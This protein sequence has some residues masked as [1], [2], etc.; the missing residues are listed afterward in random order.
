LGG[1]TDHT[2]G[3]SPF[4]AEKPLSLNRTKKKKKKEAPFSKGIFRGGMGSE[5]SKRE[6]AERVPEKKNVSW[7]REKAFQKGIKNGKKKEKGG[8]SLPVKKRK[9]EGEAGDSTKMEGGKVA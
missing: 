6:S 2:R 5:K 8:L 1:G 4:A 3:G 9:E 7:S